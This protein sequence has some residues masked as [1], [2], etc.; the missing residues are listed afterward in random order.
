MKRQSTILLTA[1]FLALGASAC[2]NDPVED[3]QGDAARVSFS[4]TALQQNVGDTDIVNIQVLDA[5]GNPLALSGVSLTSL[6]AGVATIEPLPDDVLRDVPGLTLTK[7]IVIAQGAGSTKIVVSANG[8][9]DTIKVVSYPT[10]FTGTITPAAAETGDTITITAPAGVTFG[11]TATAA[12]VGGAF[13]KF[14]SRSDTE[15]KYVAGGAITSLS[16]SGA[17]LSGTINLPTLVSNGTFA[18]TAA[19]AEPGNDAPGGATPAAGT[20]ITPPAAVGDSVM[21][22][23]TLDGSDVDDYWSI[24]T[25][26]S[27]SIDVRI[28]WPVGTPG[29]VDIDGLLY[30]QNG[31]TLVKCP[32]T[33]SNPERTQYRATATEL[34]KL[35]V[36]MYDTNGHAEHYP[37]RVTVWRR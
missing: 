33:S 30:R 37:Y 15:L 18:V 1:A 32:C 13:Y 17:I 8:V 16:V 3:L 14:V 11:P 6:D 20:T 29:D 24:N 34:Y 31:T 27:D 12:G 4:R 7:A 28:D 19:D 22:Y 25:T 21:V 5:Q 35:Q 2:F 36:N 26:T 10:A 23:G 9:N